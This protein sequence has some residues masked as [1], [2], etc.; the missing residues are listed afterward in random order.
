[1][2][3]D[4]FVQ[5][6]GQR[7]FKAV[8]SILDVMNEVDIASLLSELDDKELALAFRLIP[9][10][11]AAEVFANMETSMQTYLVDMFSEKELKELLDDLYMDDTVDLLEELPANLV[12]RIL[13]TVSPS[14]RTLINQLLNYP[15]DSAGSIM[16]T[17][18][19]DIRQSMTVAQ[20]M[21]H[22]KETGIHK[23]TI[24][25]CYVTD[26]RKLIGIVS[27]KDLMTTDDGILISEL[28]E[29]EIISV[30][31]Y[32]DKEEVAQLFRKYDLLALPVLD[33]D[34]LMVGIVTFDDAMDVMVEEATEDITKMA[35]I[36]PSEKTYFNTSTFAH[37]KN[38]IPWLLILMLTSIITGTLITK[39]EDAFAAIP[40][41]VSF[42]PMLMDTGGNCGSQSSTMIIRGMSVDEIKLKDFLK[43]IF[44][45]FRIS[46][47]ICVILAIVN[48]VRIWIM[49][50]DLQIATVVSLSII[51]IVIISQFIGCSLPMLAK[52]CKLD[53]AVMAAPLIT[54][55]VDATSIL[56][57]FNIA[58]RFFNL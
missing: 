47:V 44:T 24:Y 23:E 14:D 37:A 26:K 51:F 8:R 42:I 2:N 54:T 22:I 7:Q 12:N 1:M 33:K 36:N 55:I 39:Y 20:S 3:K 41:L 35:A 18:Y 32:T 57:F 34:G 52:R 58:T 40:L 10:D 46:L 43:V 27:A 15:E 31:T 30:R 48:G 45:E 17:E 9:K 25:T 21:A 13:D 28:M 38:R 49:S 19:V 16:T 6:L 50:G 11:K 53:P 5:L 56:I 29:T 4:I